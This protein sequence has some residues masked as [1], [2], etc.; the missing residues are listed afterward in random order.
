MSDPSQHEPIEPKPPELLQNLK[1]LRLHGWRYKWPLLTFGLLI[2]P[3]LL[4][5]VRQYVS[6]LRLLLSK[7]KPVLHASHGIPNKLNLPWMG[8]SQKVEFLSTQSTPAEILQTLAQYS[9]S[10]RDGQVTAIFAGRWLKEP[11]TGTVLA[12]PI[13]YPEGEWGVALD[14]E[15]T[16]AQKTGFEIGRFLTKQDASILRRGSRVRVSGKIVAITEAAVV[17]GD[18]SFET[19]P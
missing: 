1:W 5:Q 13:K 9:E 3:L 18:A 12:P 10:A 11:W 6:E 7:G 16:S 17:L 19:I 14:V 2:I 4:P 8:D 15:S